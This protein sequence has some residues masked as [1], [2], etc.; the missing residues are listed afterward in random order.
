MLVGKISKSEREYTIINTQPKKLI[1]NFYKSMIEVELQHI[2]KALD[3]M[4]L[5]IPVWKTKFKIYKQYIM[6]Q[7]I[8]IR[9]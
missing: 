7:E 1:N 6:K 8:Q 5:T 2:E 3:E 4:D 9:K